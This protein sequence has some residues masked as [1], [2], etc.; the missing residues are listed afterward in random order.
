M[1]DLSPST[2]P[3]GFGDAVHLLRRATL[4]PTWQQAAALVG[5]T[6]RDAVDALLDAIEVPP[7]PPSWADTP[8]EFTDF[9]AAARLWPELQEWWMAR[10]LE[11]PSLR[12]RLVLLWHNTFTTDY[13]TAYAAQWMVRQNEL[14]RSRAYDYR[15]LAEGMISDPAMLRYLNG[16]QSI[17]GNPNENFAREWF[18]L[19]TLGVG[20][21]SERDI[22][23]AARAFTGWRISGLDGVYNRGLADLGEKTILG[24]TG[25]W[26]WADVARI[27]FEQD[28]CSRWV[29]AKL[30]KAFLSFYPSDDDVRTVASLVRDRSFNVREVLRVLLASRTFYDPSVRGAL[31]KSPADLVVGLAAVL[32][33]SN[34]D[35]TYAVASMTRL[36]QEPFYPP[37]VQGWQGHHAW[38]TSS[39][40][41]QRQRFAES[42]VDGKQSGSSARLQTES[43]Q[44]LTPDVIAFIRQMPDHDDAVKVVEH[45]AALLLPIPITT[46]QRDVLLEIM[47][48]GMPVYEW[49]VNEP[50][51]VQRVKFL[52]QAIVRMP[53]FQL[54]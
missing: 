11:V 7:T 5:T 34:I 20:N 21:Y 48:A 31:I 12:E 3:L 50:S 10:L 47:L 15:S 27:T 36:T 25:P 45:V 1:I 39:S 43:G 9:A 22:T 29:A 37:T 14:I 2:S 24:Q 17:K 4:H 28:A 19:F 40:F 33:A 32:N 42:F 41:P 51:T 30:L 13:I 44:N 53:E 8:P 38:I 6:P 26:E 52:L 35:R 23:E 16:D 49:N 18:E 54:M 46:E